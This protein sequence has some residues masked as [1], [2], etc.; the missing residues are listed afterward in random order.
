MQF[1]YIIGIDISKLTLDFCLMSNA[2]VLKHIQ[3]ANE[4]KV[5][6]TEV[7]KLM[8]EYKINLS[9][10]LFC[11]EHT[12]IYNHPVLQHLNSLNAHIWVQSA[13]EI[14]RSMG[15]VRGKNDK[16]DSQ[17]IAL[18]ALRNIDKLNLWTAPSIELVKLR[19]LLSLRQGLLKA[20]QQLSVS[21]NELNGYADK[22][23]VKQINANVKPVINSINKQIAVIEKQMMQLIDEN[24]NLKRLY[25]LSTSVPGVGRI[26]AISLIVKTQEFKVINDPKRMACY[27]GVVPFEQSSGTSVRSKS[28]VSHMADKGLKNLLHMS[29]TSAIQ[30]NGELK[31]Y[32]HRKIS[33]GKSKMLVIN[34]VRNKIIHRVYACINQN[35]LYEKNYYPAIA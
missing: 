31:E 32:Y 4:S 11:M 13:I 3:I 33:E 8:K 1:K 19:H 34:A 12:G 16:V 5:I 7:K 17:R 10:V 25:T 6:K 9:E 21:S 24:Q 29:A 28:R 27:C 30:S 35:R 14:K 23:L 20:K 2:M 22:V 18:Y 15:M 26:V